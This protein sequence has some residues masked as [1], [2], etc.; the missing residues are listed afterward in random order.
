M[1]FGLDDGLALGG[2]LLTGWLNNEYAVDRQNAAQNFSAQ[3]YA[4]RYQ[5]TVSDMEKAGLNPAMA[6]SGISGSSPTGVVASS[7]ATP[8][9][10][11]NVNQSRLASAQ[12]ANIN[13]DTSNKAAQAE[14]I[15]A[16]ANAANASAGQSQ[17]QTRVLDETVSK[18]IAETRNINS[19]NMRINQ[20]VVTLA[21]QARLMNEQGKSQVYIREQ[22]K[23]AV[24]KLNAESSLLNLDA[25]AAAKLDNMGRDFGQLKPFVDTV[26]QILRSFRH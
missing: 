24:S 20:S 11:G 26:V 2:S 12:V 9:I 10:G 6:Y 23:A 3:Q 18:V 5:T 13:A 17:S 14:L 1:A 16:Q 7:N 21:E 22:L 4:S 25:A 15:R 19:E 8:D